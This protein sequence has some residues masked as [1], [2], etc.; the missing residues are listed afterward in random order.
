VLGQ[1]R[2]IEE[3]GGQGGARQ[4]PRREV[5]E[6]PRAAP[7]AEPPPVREP[8][9]PPLEPPRVREPAPAPVE[10]PAATTRPAKTGDPVVDFQNANPKIDTS[11][12]STEALTELFN[13]ASS[14]GRTQ[15]SRPGKFT[16]VRTRG[17]SAE[18]EV[19]AD[20]A[21][22]PEVVRI[23]LVPSAKGGRSPDM[24]IE[25][26]Q[27]DGTTAKTRVEV[28]AATGAAK[29]RQDVGKGTS[30][31]V[32]GVDEIVSAVRR[33]AKST[34][35]E[36]SQLE[37]PLAGVPTG[38]TIAVVLQRATAAQGP[39]DVTA[40]MAALAPELAGQPHVQAIEFYVPGPKGRAPLRYVRG[41]D[42]SYT[43]V[44]R[45]P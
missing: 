2:A 28:T 14:G 37:A 8:A 34:P 26:R 1:A 42:G 11:P 7:V 13:R 31:E 44:Q 41:A 15:T 40:A 4:Q 35:G 12:R 36:P 19:I 17:S 21:G 24:V 39:A 5:R 18:L 38:G 43:L 6:T 23:E 29:G 33:K 10:P 16:P 45:T 22:R 20:L 9:P 3:L 32:T 30:T 27:A 25:V